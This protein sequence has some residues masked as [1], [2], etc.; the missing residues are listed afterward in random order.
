MT[1][2]R[3][4][5]ILVLVAAAG[6]EWKNTSR[7]G[8]QVIA[9]LARARD[10]GTRETPLLGA[11]ARIACPDGT[12]EKLGSTDAGGWILVTTRA[13][14]R[15]ECDVAVDYRAQLLTRVA[16]RE[17][18]SVQEA[19]ECRGLQIRVMLDPR[20]RSSLT[21]PVALRPRCSPGGIPGADGACR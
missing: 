20:G 14:V 4:Q 19:G 13:P 9:P 6:C 21:Q 16:V 1:L 7:V 10:D 3:S 15:L 18:C 5:A 11:S 17:A 8:V 2:W 12:G